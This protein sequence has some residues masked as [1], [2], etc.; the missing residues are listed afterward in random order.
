MT[1]MRKPSKVNAQAKDSIAHE[2]VIEA[3]TNLGGKVLDRLESMRVYHIEPPVKSPKFIKDLE[4]TGFFEF[5]AREKSY[6]LA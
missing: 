4:K 1:K 2:Q 6:K 5:V 3:V